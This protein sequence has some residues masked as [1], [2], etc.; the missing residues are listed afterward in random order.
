M[1]KSKRYFNDKPIVT[2]S[3]D[4]SDVDIEYA[5]NLLQKAIE[6]EYSH[7]ECWVSSGGFSG[8]AGMSRMQSCSTTD[9][10]SKY[11][12]IIKKAIEVL[13]TLKE[14]RNKPKPQ[15]SPM[16]EFSIMVAAVPFPSP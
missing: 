8:M 15:L 13:K 12:G 5:I 16:H 2:R 9:A 6:K 1:R 3:I 7:N 4:I 10:R 11:N 14:E